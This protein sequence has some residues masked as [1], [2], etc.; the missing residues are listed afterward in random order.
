VVAKILIIQKAI[1]TCGTLLSLA[2][3]WGDKTV[4]SFRWVGA[5]L[6]TLTGGCGK[7]KP[8]PGGNP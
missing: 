6:F 3:A 1:V 8:W 2:A 4:G 5:D 7:S